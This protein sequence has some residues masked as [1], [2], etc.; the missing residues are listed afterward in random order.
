MSLAGARSAGNPSSRDPARTTVTR[1]AASVSR[2]SGV[3]CPAAASSTVAPM[4]SVR[5]SASVM[6]SK[7]FI[8][9]LP[10]KGGSYTRLSF[11]HR[12]VRQIAILL[13][14]IE[15]VAD[16]KAIFDGE[17]NVLDCDVD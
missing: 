12:D 4:S 10:P 14:V 1:R 6:M 15:P 13:R 3:T 5:A 16:D 9:D 17:A 7:C 8:D 2:A 11:E